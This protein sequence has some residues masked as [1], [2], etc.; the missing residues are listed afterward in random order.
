MKLPKVRSVIHRIAI[1]ATIGLV[2]GLSVPA[3]AVAAPVNITTVASVSS[4]AGHPVLHYGTHGAA[5]QALQGDLNAQGV[6]VVVDG[7]FGPATRTAVK[8]FQTAHGLQADGIV[9]AQTWAALESGVAPTPPAQSQQPVLR[10]GA[11]GAVV[12]QLQSALTQHGIAVPVVGSFG[13]VT[14]AAVKSLQ[15][16]YG[17]VVDGVVGPNTWR[18]LSLPNVVP[19]SVPANTGVT[20][21]AINAAAVYGASLDVNK[22]THK[23][24]FLQYANGSVYVARTSVVSFAGCN[25]DGCFT[26]PLGVFHVVRKAGADERSVQWHN[27]PMP[28]AVYYTWSGLAVH[29]D[30]LS[31]SHGCTHVPDGVVMQ[32]INQHIPLGALV[33]YH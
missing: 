1:V 2:L 33:I 5:V 19:T 9:G 16:R 24:Y 7:S 14:L 31:P 32:F 17:L 25:A 4:V 20:Q 28:W 12:S 23:L 18:A 11:R 30:A 21:T 29:Q 22:V 6:S 3:M 26:T 8:A 27:L 10:Y 13:P 15:A